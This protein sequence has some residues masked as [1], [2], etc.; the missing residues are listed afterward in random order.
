M[1]HKISCGRLTTEELS[2]RDLSQLGISEMVPGT[3]IPAKFTT[4]NV[5]KFLLNYEKLRVG[6]QIL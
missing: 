1:D 2:Q 3:D 4:L 5:H 6:H